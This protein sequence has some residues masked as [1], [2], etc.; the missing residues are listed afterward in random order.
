MMIAAIFEVCLKA[1]RKRHYLKIAADLKPLLEKV[2]M[3]ALPPKAD[4]CSA[5]TD[6]RFVP[7]ADVA[8][9]RS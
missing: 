9:T 1:D 8:P 3:S 5:Q 7:K 6:V 4:M 2:T